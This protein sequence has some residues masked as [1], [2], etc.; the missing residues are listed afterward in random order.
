MKKAYEFDFVKDTQQV[1]RML[2][3]ALANPG[4]VYS[5]EKQ[6]AGF[7]HPWKEQ[8]A[9]G[10]TLLDN[11]T[12]YYVE[13]TEVL[14]TSL[15][16][17]TLAEPVKIEEA[18][19]IFLTSL[20]NYVNWENLLKGVRRGTLADPQ[21]SATI[22]VYTDTFEGTQ[23]VDLEGPGIDGVYTRNMPEYMYRLLL[24][25][26]EINFEY[27]CGVDVYFVNGAGEIM[28]FPR[29][30]KISERKVG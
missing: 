11:E 24:T 19:Y 3:Q 18:Q 12:T 20:I 15:A 8:L 10:C 5:I 13:K 2:L 1:F 23:E 7:T 28:G 17:L 22:F 27:P 6:A 16:E 21:Q 9:I 25:R 29:L 30:C 26:Q 14:H 4:R